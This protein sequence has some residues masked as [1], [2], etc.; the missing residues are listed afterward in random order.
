M[1]TLK[2]EYAAEGDVP[3]EVA[4]LYKEQDGKFVLQAT[5]EGMKTQEDVTKVQTALN[6]EREA[7]KA[8][9]DKFDLLPAEVDLEKLQDD[10]DELAAERHQLQPQALALRLWHL[11]YLSRWPGRLWRASRP[12][13]RAGH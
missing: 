9:K 11:L 5:I 6:K 10:L 12:S 3:T 1:L 2:R 8:L 4:A 13:D 7:H